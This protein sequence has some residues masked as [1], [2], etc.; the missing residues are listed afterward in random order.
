[1]YVSSGRLPHLLEPQRYY[2]PDTADHELRSVFARA[3]RLVGTLDELSEPGRFLTRT[4]SGKPVVVR[5]FDGKI[6]ALSNVCA[7][8]HCLITGR[9]AGSAKVL[10]CQYHGWEYGADGV[11][12]HAPDARQFAPFDS[13]MPALTVYPT[14]LCGKLVFV[15]LEK[16]AASLE[17]FLG[18]LYDDCAERFGPDWRPS[19]R[20]DDDAAANWKVAVENALE[21]YH[22]P[23]VHAGT[24]GEDPGEARSEHRLL[25]SR[26]E[27]ATDLP[28]A[29]E[30]L[31][32]RIIHAIE[33]DLLRIC[34]RTP[35]RAYRHVHVFPNLLFSFTDFH[36]IVQAVEPQGPARSQSLVRQYSICA[37]SWPGWARL[38]AKGWSR[39][40]AGV[41]GQ[42]LSE[43]LDLYPQV[44]Q[45]LEHSD[46]QG[47]LGRCEERI[48]A[49][50]H[51]LLGRDAARPGRRAPTR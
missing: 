27:F 30:S 50:Q 10:R 29:A 19:L 32:A 3:W 9:A 6:Q 17:D 48:H 41:V 15:A 11:L 31:P 46:Q 40:G 14:A 7:H 24:F 45:G 28:F 39:L 12:A 23:Q 33:T 22:V 36:S 42:I 44:Q 18:P 38:A 8:R 20:R 4:L 35:T 13:D 16:P 1:M 25:P 5:N 49:F 37:R 34:G 51:W 47:V 2:A 26:T 21:S 43:D